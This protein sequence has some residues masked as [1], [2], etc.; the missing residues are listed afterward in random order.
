MEVTRQQRD[1]DDLSRLDPYWAILS[2]PAK[3]FGRWD[4]EEFLESGRVEIES[5]MTSAAELGR[6][7]RRGSALDFGCGTGRLTRA[8]GRHFER[9]VGVDVSDEM[10]ERAR[11]INA[12][13]ANCTFVVNA[14][15]DLRVFREG[16]FDL[17]YSRL[18]LQHVARRAAI[19]SY[20]T[21][22]VRVLAPGGLLAFQLPSS[23]PLRHRIQPRPRLYAALRRVGAPAGLL[24]RRLHLQPIRMSFLP[25]GEVRSLVTAAGGRVVAVET[26]TVTAGIESS[27]YFV[28][29]D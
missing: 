26:E 27:S 8:L 23:I 16:E 15:E 11:R 14:R 21:E 29:S 19:R 7:V 12:D 22:L 1:W 28:V 5:L 4:L 9:C 17:V 6:P 2:D 20:V 10:V 3:R 24:Y 18:V 13:A 25:V